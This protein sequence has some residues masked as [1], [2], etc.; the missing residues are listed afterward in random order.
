MRI[1]DPKYYAAGQL[2]TVLTRLFATVDVVVAS[3][4]PGAAGGIGDLGE[5][6]QSARVALLPESVTAGRLHFLRNE[7]SMAALSSSA[8]RGA[9]ATDDPDEAFA[10]VPECLHQF[11]R[12]HELYRQ[13]RTYL[14]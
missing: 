11:V 8:V 1:T 12:H 5:E 3:R 13:S 9:I 10:M 6:E 14:E 2:D 7:P 4:D